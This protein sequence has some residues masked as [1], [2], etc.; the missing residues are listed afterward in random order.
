[1]QTKKYFLTL[2]AIGLSFGTTL[3]FAPKETA[4]YFNGPSISHVSST[5]AHL[6]LSSQVLS[7]ITDE[8]KQGIYFEYNETQKVC[9]MIYPTPPECLPKKTDVGSTSMTI[10]NL[11]PNTSYTVTYKRDNTIRCITTPCPGNEF[12]SLSTEFKTLG[13]GKALGRLL[14]NKN[15]GQGSRGSEVRQLQELL[16]QEGL[17]SAQAT[18]YYGMLTVQAVRMYQKS[19]GIS[20]TG[21]VGVKTRE[22]LGK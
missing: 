1:M 5:T 3:A 15:L 2:V 19:K 10:S 22:A 11:T 18:G 4:Q 7:G 8:E 6:S 13:N 9:L 16:I 17:L 21:F 14:L 20:Q 12:E